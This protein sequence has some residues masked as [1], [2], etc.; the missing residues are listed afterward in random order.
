MTYSKEQNKSPEIGTEETQV[1]DL[2]EKKF[3]TIVLNMS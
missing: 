2:L 1:L 3:K